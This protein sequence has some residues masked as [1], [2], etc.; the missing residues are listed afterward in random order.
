ME[1]L[2]EEAAACKVLEYN[3]DL[4]QHGIK[5]DEVLPVDK[6]DITFAIP[7]KCPDRQ[8]DVLTSQCTAHVVKALRI[9]AIAHGK[10]H[11]ADSE[12]KDE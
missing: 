2:R 12:Q 9:M 1:K 11:D 3:K 7:K 6:A 8:C 10:N 4:E 5:F